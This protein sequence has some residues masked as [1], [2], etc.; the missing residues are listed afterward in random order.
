MLPY[1]KMD[2][3]IFEI[4]ELATL[5]VDIDCPRGGSLLSIPIHFSELA[6]LMRA[7][8]ARNL[9]S[10]F[11]SCLNSYCTFFIFHTFGFLKNMLL[12]ALDSIC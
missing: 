1:V 9:R 7:D 6:A 11:R 5:L 2:L 3:P 12:S 8:I 10:L 4:A